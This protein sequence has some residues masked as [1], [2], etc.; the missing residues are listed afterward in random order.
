MTDTIALFDFDGTLTRKDSLGEFIKFAVGK[1]NYY[2]KLLLFSP[3]FVLY[4]TKL[5]DNS[6]AK[7]LLFKLYFNGV[8]KSYFTKVAREYGK[9]KIYDIIREE[10]YDKFLAHIENGDRVLIVSASM[11]CWLEPF[12]TKHK[13]ELLCTELKFKDAKFTGEFATK[14]CHGEEKLTRVQAYLNLDDY[15]KIYTYGDSSGDD[16]ILAIAD[17]EV[18]VK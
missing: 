1:P 7:K 2:A 18:K 16:A 11:K 9:T 5:M 13:V 12:A 14:N 8:T 17:V 4:K 6:Y 10:I 15:E 3:I